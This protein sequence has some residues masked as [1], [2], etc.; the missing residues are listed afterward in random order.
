[1]PEIL[2]IPVRY[3]PK[4]RVVSEA[5][6]VGRWREVVIGPDFPFFPGREQQALL[7]HEAGHHQ[8]GHIGE[9]L[10]RLWL[11]VVRPAAFADLCCRQELQADRFTAACGYGPD[12][13]RA[14][15][16]LVV[17]KPTTRTERFLA[18][19]HPPLAQRIAVVAETLPN[20]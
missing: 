10:R 12:L 8:H 3:D 16:R 7:L 18:R 13:I 14:F 15:G 9:R 5:R 1:M 11:I 17:R 4:L 20:G 19:M 2:G 6:G